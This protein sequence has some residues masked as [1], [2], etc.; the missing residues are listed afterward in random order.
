MRF[1]REEAFR[2]AIILVVLLSS[3]RA[4]VGAMLGAALGDA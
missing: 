3:A 4:V 1:G 2:E